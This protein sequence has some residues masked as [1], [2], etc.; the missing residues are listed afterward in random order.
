MRAFLLAV[1]ICAYSAHFCLQCTLLLTVHI[2][3]YNA[4]I[5]HKHWSIFAYSAHASIVAYSAH[6]SIFA[7]SA[8]ALV[9]MQTF[10][11]YSAHASICC[12]CEHCCLQSTCAC[13][14]KH[15]SIQRK[16]AQNDEESAVLHPIA[17]DKEATSEAS[18]GLPQ[19]SAACS[20]PHCSAGATVLGVQSKLS[21]RT[22]RKCLC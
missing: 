16:Y 11:A 5:L 7:C 19:K 18:R 14:H 12:S 21:V 4:S 20:P 10:V 1:H 3:A 9:H 6:A 22:N 8:H 15:W 17:K 2:V 13:A